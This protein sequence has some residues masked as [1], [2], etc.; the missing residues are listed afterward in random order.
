[1]QKESHLGTKEICDI[2]NIYVEGAKERHRRELIQLDEERQKLVRSAAQKIEI[3][4]NRLS[5]TVSMLTDNGETVSEEDYQ[6]IF[7][8]LWFQANSPHQ[9][10][11]INRGFQEKEMFF[12]ALRDYVIGMGSKLKTVKSGLL[13]VFP[14]SPPIC[15]EC[16]FSKVCSL[17]I[18]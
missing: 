8:A 17:S 3:D 11:R 14:T 6:R 9:R 13:C 12:L 16:Y 5:E 1:M 7:F 2:L 4:F 18:I 10:N 15:Q